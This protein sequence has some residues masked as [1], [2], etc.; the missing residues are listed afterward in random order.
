METLKLHATDALEL[1]A[2]R[3]VWWESSQWSF[4]H[5]LI[6][7]ASVMNLCHWDDLVS[8]REQIDDKTLKWVLKNAPPG[9]FNYRSWDYWHIKLG[10][11]PIPLLPE[12]K[13]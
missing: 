10:V 6:F 13:I 12:R 3:Y 1:L 5:P 11:L 7:L 9:Y 8:L 2:K 4:T